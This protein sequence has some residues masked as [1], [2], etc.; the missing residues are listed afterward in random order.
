MGAPVLHEEAIFPARQ[1][2][3]PIQIRNTNKV[4]DEGTR[5]VH[6]R[7]SK[8]NPKKITGIAGKKGFTVVSVEK[9]LMTSD[10][11]FFRKLISVFESNEVSID[12]MPSSIDS[13]SVVIADEELN[14]KLNKIMEEIRI[15][16]KPDN[17]ISH[18]NM[19]LLAIVGTGMVRTKGISAKIFTALYSSDIN[20]R[21]ISQGSSE[22]NIIVGV[23]NE[24]YEK[25]IQAIYKAFVNERGN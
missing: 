19:A 12:H 25:S 1:K 11:S 16:C 15:Y 6:N 14:G 3:I 2:S 8:T 24:D 13:V 4:E 9:T 21:M 18:T 20:I 10:R 22:L 23:E 5:I 7:Q 17:I